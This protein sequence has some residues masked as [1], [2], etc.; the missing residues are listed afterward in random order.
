M[1]IYVEK[2]GEVYI[3]L[4]TTREVFIAT[5]EEANRIVTGLTLADIRKKVDKYNEALEKNH[6]VTISLTGYKWKKVLQALANTWHNPSYSC[7][8]WP[9]ENW[10]SLIKEV[11]Q[12]YDKAV[13]NGKS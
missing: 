7:D 3:N 4:D 9:R 5:D 13:K 8:K 2:R 10:D 11:G 6:Q 1:N 12:K